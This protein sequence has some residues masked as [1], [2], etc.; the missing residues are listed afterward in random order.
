[1]SDQYLAEIRQ[2]AFNF[3]PVGWAFCNGQTLAISQN[4]ALFS[5]LGTT[6]GGNGTTTFQLPNLQSRVAIHQGQGAGLSTYVIGQIGGVENV[7]LTV[8]QMPAHNHLVNAA[9]DLANHGSPNS[10]I[11]GASDIPLYV[12]TPPTSPVTMSSTMIGIAGGSQSHPNIQPY[13]TLTFC[14]ALVGIYPSRN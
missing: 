6:Y 2:F 7:T 3:A 12:T 5:L 1:M 10:K 11:L 9:G 8:A 14:I 13:L 4:A